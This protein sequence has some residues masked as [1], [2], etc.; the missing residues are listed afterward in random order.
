MNI[1][2][3]TAVPEDCYRIRPL[4]DEIAQLHYSVRF[5]LFKPEPRYFTEESLAAR[6]SDPKHAVY[7]AE[8]D[9]G[10]VVGYVFAWVISYEDHPVYRDHNCFYIDDICILSSHRRNRIGRM[11]FD[12]CTRRAREMGCT[13]VE[14]GVWAFNKNAIDFYKSCGMSEKIIRMEYRLEE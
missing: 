2:I 9:D 6:L 8:T 12:R 10:Q 5:D 14:L 11:L 13:R 7:I 4:Q 3:R 1:N